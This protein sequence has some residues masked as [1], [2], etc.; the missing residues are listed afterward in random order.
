MQKI[1]L[2]TCLLKS[3]TQFWTFV[4]SFRLRIKKSIRV[5][6]QLTLI[7]AKN[8]VSSTQINKSQESGSENEVAKQEGKYLKTE[9]PLDGKQLQNILPDVATLLKKS[10][11]NS[12]GD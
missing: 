7:G 5:L 10:Q 8:M 2:N 3:N 6:Q 1:D 4:S 12:D 11:E 9:N